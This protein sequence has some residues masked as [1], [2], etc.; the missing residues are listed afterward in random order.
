MI[1]NDLTGHNAE[2]SPGENPCITPSRRPACAARRRSPRPARAGRSIGAPATV[3]RCATGYERVFP[4]SL[5]T[6]RRLGEAP[7]SRPEPGLP[8]L[9]AAARQVG[10]Q[11]VRSRGFRATGGRRIPYAG[12]ITSGL[13]SV[14]RT[15]YAFSPRPRFPLPF[16]RIPRSSAPTPRSFGSRA[17]T[18]GHGGPGRCPRR[19]WDRAGGAG[20]RPGGPDAGPGP[21][22]GAAV[23]PRG[24]RGAGGAGDD[25]LAATCSCRR[26]AACPGWRSRRWRPG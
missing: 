7:A 14:E 16:R 1:P 6:G 10:P 11:D 25:R 9:R 23:V 12:W 15:R 20:R 2:T 19:G 8:I 26:S 5:W 4:R 17:H 3:H 24:V 13:E 21:G 22:G 18:R